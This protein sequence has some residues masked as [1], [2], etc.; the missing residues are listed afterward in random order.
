MSA[1]PCGPWPLRLDLGIL[2]ANS[3]S[4]ANPGMEDDM[5][6]ETKILKAIIASKPDH[7]LVNRINLELQRAGIRKALFWH[8]GVLDVGHLV[9]TRYEAAAA[10]KEKTDGWIL[11]DGHRAGHG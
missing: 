7:S 11:S 5:D 1:L 10:G 6:Q 8:A 9:A 3:G 2:I 4:G